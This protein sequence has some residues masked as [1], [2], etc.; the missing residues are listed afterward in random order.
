MK[1]ILLLLPILVAGAFLL[2]TAHGKAQTPAPQP[3]P[4]GQY[5][6]EIT[7]ESAAELDVLYRLNIDI[8]SLRA[9]DNGFPA[10]S[11]PFETLIATVY[12]TPAEAQA[13]AD[14]GLTAVP[15]PNESQQDGPHQPGDWPSF[16]QFV[17]RMQTI[18]SSYPNLVRMV[19]IGKS[20]QNRDI[21]C[22][23]ITDNPDADEDEPEV[24]Y[25]AAIHGDEL[26]GIEITLRLAELLTES[27]G[28]NAYLTSLVDEMEIW[29]CPISN[30]DGYVSGS[31][32]NAHGVNLNRDFPD[33]FLDPVDDPAGHEAET[34]AFMYFGYDHRFVMGAN[35]HGGAE[36]VNYPWDAV[37]AGDSPPPNPTPAPDDQLFHDFSVG[38]AIRNPYIWSAGWPG[39]VTRGWEWYQIWGGMQDWAYVWRGEH[40][41]TIEL[42]EKYLPYSQMNSQWDYNRDSMIWWMSRALTGVRGRVTGADTGAPLDAVVQVQGMDAP[43]SVRTDPQA[44][45]YHRVIGPGTYNLLA[46]AACYQDATA[47]VMV[48]AN[49]SATV[50]NFSLLPSDWTVE[51]TV[52]EWGSG[53]PLT[54]TV[55]IV[56]AGLVTP[57][58]PLDGSYAFTH[59]CGGT[60]TLRASAPGYQIEEREIDLDHDQVQDFSLHPNPCTLLVDDDLGQSYQTY[61]QNALAAVGE[62]YDTWSVAASG[63]PSASTL[64]DYKRVIWLT[65]DD[66]LS[67]LTTADQVNLSGYLED[68]GRLFLSGQLIGVDIQNT[69]FYSAYLHADWNTEGDSGYELT[70]AGYLSGLNIHIQDGDGAGNQQ[71]RSD[72]APLGGAEAALKYA[73]PYLAGGVTYQDEVYGMVYFSFGFEGIDNAADRTEVMGRTLDFL[74]NCPTPPSGLYTSVKQASASS[75][76]PGE[77]VTY[78]VTLHNTLEPAI[79]TLTDTLPAG[80]AFAGTLTATQGTPA[81][82]NGVISW[83]GLL[84]TGETA[85]IT[86]TAVLNQCLAG[87]PT[88]TNSAHLTDGLGTTITRT[89]TVTFED[90]A[91]AIPQALAPADEAVNVQ[92]STLLSWQAADPNCDALTYSV[93]FSTSGTPPIVAEDLTVPSF[94][95]GLL[96]PVTTYYWYVTASDGTYTVTSPTWSFTTGNASTVYLP[97]V[98]K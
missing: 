40:H 50:Q 13:L 81:Y 37:T 29:L 89:A 46:S 45:D 3:Y 47:A 17:T 25:T 8:G 34:Q 62:T 71:H 82:A 4:T 23:E 30:P 65:G 64:A 70:G 54:A 6:A 24:K 96:Q 32:E 27:Y 84:A 56:G 5:P 83:Q 93:A 66:Y 7:L 87:G 43:N 79:E 92:V 52:T 11:D 51:G 28:G 78:T 20:V 72:V 19:S 60:Y 22:L 69:S 74:G 63:S 39:P 33:R 42:S 77:V 90:L 48:T 73:P 49:L 35:F 36:V 85:A 9:A 31:R 16:A 67:T 41:V 86:Y 75:A 98:T 55:E 91:P 68:G 26:T 76:A 1:R 61:Y 59:M 38:Y 18:T 95:P 58:N 10:A 94:D 21:W 80:L 2:S 53:R 57:T 44:G 97:V 14:L 15:I 88:I 12:I